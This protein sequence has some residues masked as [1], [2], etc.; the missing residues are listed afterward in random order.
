MSAT[1]YILLN[2][3]NYVDV[4]ML[5]KFT[6]IYI[7]WM[8]GRFNVREIQSSCA[9]SPMN[10]YFGRSEISSIEEPFLA[11]HIYRSYVDLATH[12]GAIEAIIYS[13]HLRSPSDRV[14]ASHRSFHERNLSKPSV[15]FRVRVSRYHRVYNFLRV[16][17]LA[18]VSTVATCC[19]PSFLT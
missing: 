16:A 19:S 2:R 18:R 1:I 11:C 10:F 14:I 3:S 6:L 5:I 8:A 4:R 15:S 7:D 12:A 9:R 17:S 13:S